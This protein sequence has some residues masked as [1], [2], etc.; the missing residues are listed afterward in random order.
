MIVY[1]SIIGLG[2]LYFE[3]LNKETKT[4]YTITSL[5]SQLTLDG[6]THQQIQVDK[7]RVPVATEKDDFVFLIRAYNEASTIERVIDTIIAA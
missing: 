7:L 1:I 6:I 2:Y 3:L 5:V 4:S